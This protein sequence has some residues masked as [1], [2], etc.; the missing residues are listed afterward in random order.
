MVSRSEF[1]Q[2]FGEME[3]R[4]TELT[5]VLNERTTQLQS[6]FQEVDLGLNKH[7]Q[8]ILVLDSTTSARFSSLEEA[9]K[10]TIVNNKEANKKL[11][12]LNGK[13]IGIEVSVDEINDSYSSSYT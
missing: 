2:A 5:Q 13:A 11:E 12:F 7:E 8:M 6:K 4:F 3:Q 1:T 10:E 9:M